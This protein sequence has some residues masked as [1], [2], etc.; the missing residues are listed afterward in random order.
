M[1]LNQ[2][3]SVESVENAYALAKSAYAALG[4]NTDKAIRSALDIPISIQCWQ[5]D[6]VVGFEGSVGA[7]GGIIATGNY[8]GRARNGDELRADAEFA[9][10]L[11]P[12]KKRFNL[13]SFYAETDGKKVMRD[14][15]EPE[16]FKKWL[17]WSKKKKI[18]LDFNPSLFAHPNANSGFT[19]SSADPKIRDFWIRHSKASRKIAAEFGANQNSPAVNNIWI[20]DGSK[21][22]P[23]DRLSPRLRLMDALDEILAVKYN[24]DTITDAVESK[25]FGIGSESYVVGSHEFYMGYAASKKIR[26]CL[27]SGH[28]HPTETLV[29]KVSAAMLFVPGLLIHFSRG[30]RWDSDHVA[31]YSDE[32]RDLCREIIRHKFLDRVDIAL[33]FF[34]A[35]INRIAAWSI[36]TRS[37]RKGLLESLLEPYKL[38]TDAEKAGKYT[39]RLALMEE[40]KT[41]PF[42]A[43]WDKLCLVDKVPV[44]MNWLSRVNQYE[45]EVLI[46][47]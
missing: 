14:E 20:P 11:I 15:L 6:D 36:G 5:G 44:G 19:L 45:K 4:V 22:I 10:S 3:S 34:D 27:D 18:P 47:R 31:I 7:G 28:F 32:L 2:V 43:V 8:P 40:L 30:V 17:V 16:H 35:S 37:L 24:T 23:A 9:F 25:L 29:D 26:L 12:G 21:D 33:D 42:Q 46:N 1:K 41:L 38:L 13:H 39:E